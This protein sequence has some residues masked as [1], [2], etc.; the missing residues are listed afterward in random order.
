MIL[1]E[2]L[3]DYDDGRRKSVYCLAVNL[4]DMQEINTVM[5]RIVDEIEPQASVKTKAETA[6]RLFQAKADKRGIILK[7]RK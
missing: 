2:L 5:R 7:L 6:V 4:L 3:K 1:K